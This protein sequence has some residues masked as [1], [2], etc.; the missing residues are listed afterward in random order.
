MNTKKFNQMFDAL[1]RISQYEDLENLKA[2]ADEDYGLDGNEAVE[3]AYE[4]V[5]YEARQGLRGV[6]RGE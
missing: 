3:M 5:L 6:V 2:N 4:N 1:Q